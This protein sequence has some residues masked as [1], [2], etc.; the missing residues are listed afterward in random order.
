MALAA[1]CLEA[2]VAKPG[3]P[4]ISP[5]IR[6]AALA[7]V[8]AGMT[9]YGAA[10]KHKVSRRALTDWMIQS[11]LSAP[12]PPTSVRQQIW[13]EVDLYLLEALQTMRVHLKI[14]RDEA[15][16]KTH[17]T[18]GLATLHNSFAEKVARMAAVEE[19]NITGAEEPTPI[20]R[21]G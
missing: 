13:E 2:C 20:R 15:W 6:A 19:G 21:T 5:E 8:L 10:K 4:P 9:V 14:G 17:D 12:V 1:C 7:D 18:A 11:G 3:R 16:I